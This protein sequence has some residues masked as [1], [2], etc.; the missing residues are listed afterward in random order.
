M[1]RNPL[2][3][4]NPF[5]KRLERRRILLAEGEG[6]IR[7][8]NSEVLSS[9]GYHVDAIDNGLAAWNTLQIN[10]YDLL[11]IAEN[12][13]IVSG[14]D[15]L[16]KMHYT[17]IYLPVILTIRKMPTWELAAHPWM[18][19]TTM[20]HA[21]YSFKSLITKVKNLLQISANSR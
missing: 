12:L 19:S 18:Q 1:K 11:I 4:Q 15:L 2:R 6:D 14:L 8:L 17:G 5:V 9:F 7:R 21:P 3:I 13:P 10:S 16:K 20:L